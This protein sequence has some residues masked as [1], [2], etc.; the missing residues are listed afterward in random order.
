MRSVQMELIHMEAKETSA[1]NNGVIANARP[2][3]SYPK[4]F[5]LT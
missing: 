3:S 1:V 5:A 4:S 2:V